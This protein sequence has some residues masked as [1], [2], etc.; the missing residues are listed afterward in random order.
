M[1]A[2]RQKLLDQ[3]KEFATDALETVSKRAIQKTAETTGDLN[4]SKIAD[5][6]QTSQE[7]HPKILQGQ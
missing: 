5:K 3:A 2:S 6:L 1:L 4:G 7:L